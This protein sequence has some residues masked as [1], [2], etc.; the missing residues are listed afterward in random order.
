MLTLIRCPFHPRVTAVA[1]KRP[2][3]FCQKRRWQVTPKHTYTFD[4]TKSE[5]ADYATVQAQCGNL[6]GNELTRNSTGNTKAQAG[7]ELS[8]ILPKSSHARKK[9]PSYARFQIINCRLCKSRQVARQGKPFL[10]FFP[11]L[12]F[13]RLAARLIVSTHFINSLQLFQTECRAQS[14]FWL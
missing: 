10:S 9:P 2:Q 13:P 5:W 4:S 11:S 6:S 14:L 8:N 3:S 1:R 12:R 7:N